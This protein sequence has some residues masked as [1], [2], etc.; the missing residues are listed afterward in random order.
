MDLFYASRELGTFTSLKHIRHKGLALEPKF[1]IPLQCLNSVQENRDFEML[2][3]LQL[4]ILL[5]IFFSLD[6]F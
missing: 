5:T 1:V 6:V 4:F 3:F 2:F